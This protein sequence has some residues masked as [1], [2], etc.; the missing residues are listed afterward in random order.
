MSH[1]VNL[2]V[3]EFLVQKIVKAGTV[4]RG[5]AMVLKNGFDPLQSGEL[6]KF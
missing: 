4:A 1:R 5:G 3:E 2:R 6:R